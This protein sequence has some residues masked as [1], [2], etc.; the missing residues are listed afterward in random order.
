M[1]LPDF[2]MPSLLG[3][4]WAKLIGDAPMR[5]LFKKSA[6]AG[7]WLTIGMVAQT[8]LRLLSNFIMV[9]LLAPEAFGLITVAFSLMT[10]LTM[11]TDV[12]LMGNVVRS[13]RGDDP[14]FLR[15]VWSSQIVRNIGIFLLVQ[16]VAL[17]LYL[18][19]D[20]VPTE[21]LYALDITPFFISVAA[22]SILI[23][24]FAS[25]TLLVALRSMNLRRVTLVQIGAK[26]LSL[27][28]MVA[29]AM[30]G[31]GPWSLLIGALF[32][33]VTIT[34]AS[35]TLIPGVPMRFGFDREA[36]GEIFSFGK[37]IMLASLSTYLLTQADQILFGWLFDARTFSLYGVAMIWVRAGTGLLRTLVRKLCLP[38]LSECRRDNPQHLV[39]VYNRL[40]LLADVTC[41]LSFLSFLFFGE[42]VLTLFLPADYEEATKFVPLVAFLFIV[43]AFGLV[44]QMLLSEGDSR[45]YAV[46][47]L[48][49]AVLALVCIPIAYSY[50]GVLPAVF[51]FVILSLASIP[52]ALYN[53]RKIRNI[54]LL[55]EA[56]ILLV[57]AGGGA[58][59][60]AV[61]AV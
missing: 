43:P 29:A 48:M 34:I 21:S 31:C 12:G 2:P 35:H 27:P 4:Y 47:E 20:S 54:S 24:G 14:V 53:L 40:R 10:L 30:A 44:Q 9:R 38:A 61:H 60:L 41:A 15:T 16:I 46:G 55:G 18:N 59:Y 52:I 5:R 50:L 42:F 23:S 57:A 56:R 8:V 33:A 3:R 13:E 26:T 39:G 36:F 17:I 51:T 45:T 49:G 19:Q 22:F 58:L 32:Q 11:I 25:T 28:V 6:G 1:N 7:K 37:W